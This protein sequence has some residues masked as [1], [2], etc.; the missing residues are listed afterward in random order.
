M[1]DNPMWDKLQPLKAAMPRA[2][3]ETEVLRVAGVLLGDD[4]INSAGDARQEV[5]KWVQKRC[6]G[7]LPPE[8]WQGAEFNYLAGGRNSA[9]V[10]IQTEESNV[11]AVRAEYSDVCSRSKYFVALATRTNGRCQRI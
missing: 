8:S 2:V 7:K 4:P 3:T 6:G 1:S 11:W 10:H 5:L 9:G